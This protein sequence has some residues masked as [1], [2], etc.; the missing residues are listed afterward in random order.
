[1]VQVKICGI[2]RPCDARAA[3][4][5]GVDAVGLVFYPGSRR[6]VS[7]ERAREIC[8]GLP[9]FTTV[10]GLFVDPEPEAVTEVLEVVPVNLLQFHGNETPVFCQQFARPYLKAL[11]V[12]AAMD[13]MALMAT[14]AE[15][16]GFLVDT[17]DPVAHGGTGRSFDWSLLE[18]VPRE[19][20]VLAGGLTPDNVGAAIAR[21]RPAG[22]DVSSGVES[23]P[24]I[25]ETDKL[26]AFIS[27]ARKAAREAES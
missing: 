20:L 14:H 17:Y 22:V 9:P 18:G 11:G 8:G 7:V 26:R 27:A 2:T 25:K 24:G 6:C 4:E 5:A 3:A 23:A 15:A 10:V 16:R 19:A 21:V 13:P 1:M 12:H